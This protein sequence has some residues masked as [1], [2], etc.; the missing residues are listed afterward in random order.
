MW[1][2]KTDHTGQVPNM[3]AQVILLVLSCCGS[4]VLVLLW[5]YPISELPLPQWWTVGRLS[6]AVLHLMFGNILA[7]SD[8]QCIVSYRVV[9]LSPVT[10]MCKILARKGAGQLLLQSYGH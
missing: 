3:G 5:L 6:T 7:P 9:Q 8:T 10:R 1:T 4:N 2:M